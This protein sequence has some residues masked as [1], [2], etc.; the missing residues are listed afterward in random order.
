[1]PGLWVWGSVNQTI[2]YSLLIPLE[3]VCGAGAWGRE[4]QTL[5]SVAPLGTQGGKVKSVSNSETSV[6]GPEMQLRLH[7]EERE[8]WPSC[9]DWAGFLEEGAFD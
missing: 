7:G 4:T 3:S 6:K 1:M 8:V 9:V 2:A 5:L